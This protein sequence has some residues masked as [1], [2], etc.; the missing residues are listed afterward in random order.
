M[1]LSHHIPPVPPS[2][3]HAL[4][5]W[6]AIILSSVFLL[7]L[8]VSVSDPRKLPSIAL[9]FSPGYS[10]LGQAQSLV[11]SRISSTSFPIFT[12][13][14]WSQ[15]CVTEKIKTT[16]R[17]PPAV[18]LAPL[19]T[20]LPLLPNTLPSSALGQSLHSSHLSPAWGHCSGNSPVNLLGYSYK[21]EKVCCLYPPKFSGRSPIN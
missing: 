10:H 8:P 18:S 15:V 19:P 6:I 13:K 1:S 12:F 4:R 17:E 20:H 16:K 14:W 9:P 21:R 2:S 11:W 3:L 5:L 7:N